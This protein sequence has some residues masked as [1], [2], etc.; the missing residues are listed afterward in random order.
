MYFLKLYN[1]LILAFV[2]KKQFA[3]FS[4]I[5][6]RKLCNL[7]I[8]VIHAPMCILY[9]TGHLI[10]TKLRF[11]F[12]PEL[13]TLEWD[14]FNPD[15][16]IR[17]SGYKY[18]IGILKIKKNRRSSIDLDIH[19]SQLW[20]PFLLQIRRITS[21]SYLDINKFCIFKRKSLFSFIIFYI[22]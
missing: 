22:W 12:N 19:H 18:K 3:K 20:S 6:E 10:Y 2:L 1:L 4:L 17:I 5:F 11:L 7:R 13:G 8:H 21:L 14:T 16:L 9:V 15:C